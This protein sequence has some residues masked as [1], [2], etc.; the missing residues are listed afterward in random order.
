MRE[1][2]ASQAVMLPQPSSADLVEEASSSAAEK[3]V[4]DLVAAPASGDVWEVKADMQME[5][6]A[7]SLI[8]WFGLTGLRG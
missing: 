1:H 8:F 6:S 3:T 5:V 4:A 2:L 7:L